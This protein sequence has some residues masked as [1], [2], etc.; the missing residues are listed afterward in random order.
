MNE[1][2]RGLIGK[3]VQVTS[4]GASTRFTDV[5]ILESYDHP[6]LRLRK[7][8]GQVICFAVYN[9]RLVEPA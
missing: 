7:S 4:V 3:Q 5:G 2:L 9:I 1:S 8:D 6:W